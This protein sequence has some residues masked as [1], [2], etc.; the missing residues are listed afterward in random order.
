MQKYYTKQNGY[1][2]E[3]LEIKYNKYNHTV[4]G[5]DEEGNEIVIPADELIIEEY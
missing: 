4:T 2:I 5:I 3:L 1:K